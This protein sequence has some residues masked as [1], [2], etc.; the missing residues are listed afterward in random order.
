M[1]ISGNVCAGNFLI[2]GP[3][4]GGHLALM[5]GL[6]LP[7]QKVAGIVSISGIADIEADF[8]AHTAIFFG[9]QSG[10]FFEKAGE[11]KFIA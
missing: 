9:R 4:A 3:S 7:E 10:V 2:I 5:T 11:V 1:A 8:S 6:R